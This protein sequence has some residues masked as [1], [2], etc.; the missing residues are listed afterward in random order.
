VI[1]TPHVPE[2][3]VCSLSKI[4]VSSFSPKNFAREF[5]PSHP[6]YDKSFTAIQNYVDIFFPAAIYLELFIFLL[7]SSLYEV[8][9]PRLLLI[10]Y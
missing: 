3:V 2:P 6:N 7:P 5:T 9:F 10:E 1:A 4:I 8:I